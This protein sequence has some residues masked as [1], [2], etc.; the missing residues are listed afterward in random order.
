MA[1]NRFKGCIFDVL[2]EMGVEA[3]EVLRSVIGGIVSVLEVYLDAMVFQKVETEIERVLMMGDLSAYT[4]VLNKIKG[5]FAQIYDLVPIEPFRSCNELNNVL[6]YMRDGVGMMTGALEVLD[7]E[8]TRR[9]AVGE[10]IG[11]LEAGVEELK[12]TLNDL[13]VV[14]DDVIKEKMGA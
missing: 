6:S 2:R 9:R 11:N 3:L 14:I 1:E 4:I 5:Y 7:V 12:N 10:V 8:A 13:I